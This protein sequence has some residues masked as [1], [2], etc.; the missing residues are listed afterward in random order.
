MNFVVLVVLDFL[1]GMGKAIVKIG[2]GVELSK[3][4]DGY[5]NIDNNASNN[6]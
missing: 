6:N 1:L 3:Y 5:L 2:N 4:G